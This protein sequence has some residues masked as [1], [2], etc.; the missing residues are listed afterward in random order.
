MIGVRLAAK[1]A[2]EPT[3]AELLATV[4]SGQISALGRLYDRHHAA[5]LRF[6]ART[7]RSSADAEDVT[8]ATFITLTR[9]AHTYDGRANCRPWML[10]V[11]ARHVA[12]RRRSGARFHRFL[13]RLFDG[14]EAAPDPEPAMA[15]R[16]SLGEVARALDTMSVEKRV[17]VVL[18]EVEG[19]SGE[20][21]A[22][23]LGIPIGTVWTRLHAARKDL[24]ARLPKETP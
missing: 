1:E 13:T 24:A 11:A 17:V 22:A 19:L 15:A 2:T 7:C 14:Q 9:I 4:A 6:A 20:E 8:H 16:E 5:V 18:F 3:D 21:I 12:E 10:G 23:S